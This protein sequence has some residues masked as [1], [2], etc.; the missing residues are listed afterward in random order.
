MSLTSTTFAEQLAVEFTK[1][2]TH[3]GQD[4]REVMTCQ[5]TYYLHPYPSP[6]WSPPYV[7]INPYDFQCPMD[8]FR[9]PHRN[10]TLD[11]VLAARFVREGFNYHLYNLALEAAQ[12][13]IGNGGRRTVCGRPV[14][15]L[16]VK[17]ASRSL[18]Y[19]HV[20]DLLLSPT[21]LAVLRPELSKSWL[22]TTDWST[23]C[24]GAY[25]GASLTRVRSS[26]YHQGG[27]FLVKPHSLFYRESPKPPTIDFPHGG[28][29]L[30]VR[31]ELGVGVGNPSA[32]CRIEFTGVR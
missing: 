22:W 30:R 6:G 8:R 14:P 32:I 16:L 13:T 31:H 27:D 28:E 10:G 3:P 1:T 15:S 25:R 7:D 20:C 9:D 23:G 18:D 2:T 19:P 11:P 4:I 5:S 12:S 24:V 29:T 26:P 21:A 17:A